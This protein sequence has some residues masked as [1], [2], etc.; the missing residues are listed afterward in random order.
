[1]PAPEMEPELTGRC[2]P[3]TCAPA[4]VGDRHRC[5]AVGPY[6]LLTLCSATAEC[7]WSAWSSWGGCSCSS[8]LQHRYRHRHGTGLCVGLDV[9]LHPCNTS[10]CSGEDGD[11]GDPPAPAQPCPHPAHTACF[12][13]ISVTRGVPLPILCAPALALRV[14][15]CSLGC[16]FQSLCTHWGMTLPATIHSLPAP[17]LSHCALG[18]PSPNPTPIPTESSCEPP[19]E[20]QPCSPPCARLC[21]TLQHPELCPA[22]SHCLPGCFCPQ[23]RGAQGGG[24]GG[25]PGGL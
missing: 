23:A 15:M 14:P 18:S 22:Q 24:P 20:F 19:F 25:H 10:G 21:S 8:P 7:S 11:V 4:Q 13:P 2:R 9:E 5:G 16:P 12:L 1:M 6:P 17:C 3:A